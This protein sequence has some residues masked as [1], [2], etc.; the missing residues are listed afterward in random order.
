MPI[1][2]E[3]GWI[4]CLAKFRR[5]AAYNPNIAM[6]F[7]MPF[8]RICSTR[9]PLENCPWRVLPVLFYQLRQLLRKIELW[10]LLNVDMTKAQ[11]NLPE[12]VADFDIVPGSV[13]ILDLMIGVALGPNDEA[14]RYLNE[15]LKV[16]G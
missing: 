13:I 16:F 12:G 14:S 9:H 3:E 10:W 15:Y 8:T 2:L 4:A 1:A 7:L 5:Y 11:D 6:T